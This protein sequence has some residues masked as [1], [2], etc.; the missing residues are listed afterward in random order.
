MYPAANSAILATWGKRKDSGTNFD[1]GMNHLLLAACQRALAYHGH[2]LLGEVVHL[3]D[4]LKIQDLH[5][6]HKNIL[7]GIS[8]Q[9]TQAQAP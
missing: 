6:M 4:Y 3:K 5:H 1:V 7:P 9:H 2:Q 8:Q